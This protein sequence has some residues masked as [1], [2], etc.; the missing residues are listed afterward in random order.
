MSYKISDIK[1]D[2]VRR[3]RDVLSNHLFMLFFFIFVVFLGTCGI[4]I[5]PIF[6]EDPIKWPNLPDRFNTVAFLSFC[7]P[8]IW[9][10]I[11]D[12]AIRVV[13]KFKSDPANFDA[14]LFVWYVLLTIILLVVVV[15]LFALGAKSGSGYSVSSSMA[16]FLILVYWCLVN[17]D[18]P[19]YKRISVTTAPSGTDDYYG[20]R[21]GGK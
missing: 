14:N 21:S 3:V 10:T 5:E 17:I 12:C 16:W 7:A 19:A 6:L 4:W 11:F 1:G 18:N 2:M 13:V 8:L 9:I 20:L 15:I